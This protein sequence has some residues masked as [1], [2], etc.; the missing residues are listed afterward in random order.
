VAATATPAHAHLAA[1]MDHERSRLVRL[2]AAITGDSHAA[3]DL[4]QDTLLQAW[5]HADKLR[6]PHDPDGIARWLDAF[7]RNVCLRWRRAHSRT[8]GHVISLDLPSTDAHDLAATGADALPASDQ[9]DPADSLERAELEHLLERAL[10]SLPPLTRDVMLR[11]YLSEMPHAAIAAELR[12]SEAVVAQRLHRGRLALRQALSGDLRQDAAAFDLPLT[13]DDAPFPT[14]I[15][16]PFCGARRLVMFRSPDASQFGFAC[17]ACSRGAPVVL[18]GTSLAH[19][20]HGAGLTSPKAILARLLLT[21]SD[22]YYGGLPRREVPCEHCGR[23]AAIDP[24]LPHQ[25]SDE[26]RALLPSQL[27]VTII[28]PTCGITD[29]T[30]LS[31]LALDL[32]EA[33]CFWR[34]HPRI[35]RLPER[36]VEAEGQPAIISTYASVTDGAR[37]EVLSARDSLQVLAIHGAP[38]A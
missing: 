37:L 30:A 2:C 16:C 36:E 29:V 1:A 31:H 24:H 3:E 34:A 17:P 5:A 28:C 8:R 33:V 27:G 38:G 25:L 21:L 9:L 11:H 35:R 10:S 20:G 26:E 7:A 23:P 18:A 4:A 14:R 12:L 22:Y 15:W 6:E 19:P 13:A 32:P